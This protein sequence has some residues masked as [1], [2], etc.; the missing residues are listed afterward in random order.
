MKL[1]SSSGVCGV[2]PAERTGKSSVR[3]W[4][5]GMRPPSS[6]ASRR[7]WKPRV[8]KA[9]AEPYLRQTASALDLVAAPDEDLGHELRAEEA[10]LDDARGRREPGRELGRVVDRPEVVGDQPAVRARR[11]VAQLAPGRSGASVAAAP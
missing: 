1:H 6:S 9:T 4:P 8:M 2:G 11:H 10:V 7:P 3:Y 5:G